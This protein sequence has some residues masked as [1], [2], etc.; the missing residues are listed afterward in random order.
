MFIAAGAALCS[1]CTM[2]TACEAFKTVIKLNGAKDL[3]DPEK[4][5][6]LFKGERID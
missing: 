5:K 6:A 2:V 1:A 4:K 3:I